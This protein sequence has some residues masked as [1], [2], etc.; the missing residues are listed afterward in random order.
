[1]GRFDKY[2]EL[3]E[4]GPYDE[5][6]EIF[7]C[8]ECGA[9]TVPVE[10]WDGEPDPGMCQHGCGVRETDWLP[11]RANRKY[12]RNFERIFPGSPGAGL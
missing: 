7:K 10:G 5:G 1:M 8:T 2:W 9:E 3:T 12:K 4:G 11:G 6:R